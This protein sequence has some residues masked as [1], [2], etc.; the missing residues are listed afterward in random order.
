MP[1][2]SFTFVFIFNLLLF[3]T[4]ANGQVPIGN[5]TLNVQ[6]PA[7]GNRNIETA[8]YYPALSSGTA[9]AVDTGQYPVIV[10][11]HGFAM[12][13]SAYQNIWEDIVPQGYI[14]VFPKTESGLFSVNH[15]EFA[16]DLQ[17]L[18]KYMQVEGQNINAPI[19]SAVAAS[20]ALMGHSMG[21]GAAFLAADSLCTTVDAT[22]KTIIGLAPA[23]SNSNGVSSISSALQ[24]N[25]PSLI[26]SGSQDGV[27]P[28]SVHH[29]PIFNNVT[30]C[31][32]FVSI[33]GG[34]HC[35]FA[36]PNFNCDFGESVSST[37]ISVSRTQQQMTCKNILIPWLDYYLKDQCVAL[38][39]FNDSIASSTV[40]SQQACT[41]IPTVQIIDS[42]GILTASLQGYSYQWY[43]ND[44]L[45]VGAINRSFVAQ[46]N[47][48][49]TVAVFTQAACPILS[50][51][52]L[53]IINSISYQQGFDLKVYPQ[54]FKDILN[55]RINPNLNPPYRISIYDVIGQCRK[56]IT[57]NNP[58]I[59]QLSTKDIE[60]GVYYLH[61]LSDA[62]KLGQHIQLI[63]S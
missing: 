59:V 17:F 37:G 53:V 44:S 47:G 24:V 7:R 56:Q 55:V 13:W 38:E 10:F 16:W 11:G 18:V 52:Y 20:T 12:D 41:T 34:G 32:T 2:L 58:R 8:I 28:P 61:I 25:C 36:G 5:Y 54:P 30:G 46:T 22:F 21:G 15:Q 27:T 51:A 26:F 3:C 45:L 63:K 40:S 23:E 31:K 14:M 1:N 4:V 62:Q 19:H 33:L 29:L 9:T 42:A 49:Y 60:P 35:Y 6:D 57:T 48:V 39:T 43:L 50:D